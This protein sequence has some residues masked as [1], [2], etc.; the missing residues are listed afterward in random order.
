MTTFKGKEKEEAEEEA[1]IVLG[2]RKKEFWALQMGCGTGGSCGCGHEDE[3]NKVMDLWVGSRGWLDER[4]GA[5][6]SVRKE[7]RNRRQRFMTHCAPK[8]YRPVLPQQ[9]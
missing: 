9:H 4:V 8:R 7:Q 3:N 5:G 2:S 6:K 1:A